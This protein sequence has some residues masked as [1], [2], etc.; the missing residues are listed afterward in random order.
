MPEASD[1]VIVVPNGGLFEPSSLQLG[2]RPARPGEVD[3]QEGMMQVSIS[4]PITSSL[5]ISQNQVTLNAA[6][7]RR[8]PPVP[9][10]DLLDEHKIRALRWHVR[11]GTWGH[12]YDQQAYDGLCN[13]LHRLCLRRCRICDRSIAQ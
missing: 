7:K 8:L 13:P 6:G 4:S 1:G 10:R 12:E 2:G 3:P 9:W 11:Q 5:S